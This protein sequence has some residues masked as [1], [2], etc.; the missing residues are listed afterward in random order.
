MA[1]QGDAENPHAFGNVRPD[2]V[3]FS[4]VRTTKD[5][6]QIRAILGDELYDEL[7]TEGCNSL[8]AL[9]AFKVTAGPVTFWP[10][11][12]FNTQERPIFRLYDTL[13]APVDGPEP[14][15]WQKKL[16][17]D[18]GKTFRVAFQLCGWK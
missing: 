8:L 12:A 3:L 5:P 1:R 10:V 2:P 6:K 13:D 15:Y 11:L 14:L 4:D 18:G 16:P 9:P 7:F 17:E